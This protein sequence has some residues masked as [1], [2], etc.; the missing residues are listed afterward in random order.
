MNLGGPRPG[1]ESGSPSPQASTLPIKAMLSVNVTNLCW[2]WKVW[3][4]LC[5]LWRRTKPSYTCLLW[6]KMCTPCHPVNAELPVYCSSVNL[7]VQTDKH[8]LL[9]PMSNQLV[10]KYSTPLMR[11]WTETKTVSIALYQRH[12]YMYENNSQS[13][14]TYKKSMMPPATCKHTTRTQI[15]C[16]VLTWSFHMKSDGVW[17]L[18][19]HLQT[20][21]KHWHHNTAWWINLLIAI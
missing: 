19:S 6:R 2:A 11:F 10:A 3:N 15:S 4:L 7:C 5:E 12:M 9:W 14:Y 18:L 1:I 13:H 8:L 21:L 16:K 20:I 17:E